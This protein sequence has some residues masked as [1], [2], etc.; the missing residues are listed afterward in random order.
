L[1]R[2]P[3]GRFRVDSRGNV[4]LPAATRTLF[5]IHDGDRVVLVASPG[6]DTLRIHPISVVTSLLANLYRESAADEHVE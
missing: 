6:N 5:G 1:Y 2:S 3:T 4:F